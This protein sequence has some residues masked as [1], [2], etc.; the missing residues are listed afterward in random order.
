MAMVI[1]FGTPQ[2]GRR[3]GA[4]RRP[5]GDRLLLKRRPRWPRSNK[6]CHYI[7][8][9]IIFRPGLPKHIPFLHKSR[10]EHVLT[11]NQKGIASAEVR[12]RLGA[13]ES[14]RYRLHLG[15]MFFIGK[16][17]KAS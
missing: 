13:H 5:R 8:L 14:W 12:P 17:K 10:R 15:E 9:A 4:G 1:I 2:G 7:Q 3:R 6:I 16:R 11:L